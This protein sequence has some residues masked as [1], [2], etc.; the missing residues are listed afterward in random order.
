LWTK[1][2][3]EVLLVSWLAGLKSWLNP[4]DSDRSESNWGSK[5]NRAQI[6]A[7]EKKSSF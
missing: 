3:E 7:L 1:V 6:R 5:R 4:S 2:Q